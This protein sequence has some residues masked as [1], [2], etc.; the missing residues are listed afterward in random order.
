MNKFDINQVIDPV[1]GCWPKINLIVQTFTHPHQTQ[2]GHIH[3]NLP[4]YIYRLPFQN[5]QGLFSKL[6]YNRGVLKTLSAKERVFKHVLVFRHFNEHV[7]VHV[8]SVFGMCA[9]IW[10]Y[11]RYGGQSVLYNVSKLSSCNIFC[12]LGFAA[13]V[14]SRHP[15]WG[16]SSKWWSAA[17]ILSH[18]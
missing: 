12:V 9:F 11:K 5:V 8:Y 7:C 14:Q 17:I 3:H 18:I 16:V 4:Y 15:C 1:V 10:R 13:G 6:L 2:T